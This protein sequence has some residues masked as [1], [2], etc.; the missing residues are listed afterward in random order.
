MAITFLRKPSALV[1]VLGVTEVGSTAC[2]TDSI[3]SAGGPVV[4]G[5]QEA[6]TRRDA[7]TPGSDAHAVEPPEAAPTDP[8][9][10]LPD[11]W[12]YF[13]PPGS[14]PPGPPPTHCMAPCLYEALVACGVPGAGTPLPHPETCRWSKDGWYGV[15]CDTGADYLIVSDAGALTYY[16]DGEACL[17]RSPPPRPGPARPVLIWSDPE[18]NIVA[19]VE[20]S[21]A[22]RTYCGS[23]NDPSSAVYDMYT[24]DPECAVW[25]YIF[26]LPGSAMMEFTSQP[27]I[28]CPEG[29]CPDPPPPPVGGDQ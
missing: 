26:E 14:I 4:A 29:E 20:Y 19:E 24:L 3:E 18:G 1:M 13:Y 11:P 17:H 23:G 12:D 28:Y 25:N 7:A 2:S 9:A 22:I 10:N 8:W 27:H 6:G 5:E 16:R 21:P 15:M